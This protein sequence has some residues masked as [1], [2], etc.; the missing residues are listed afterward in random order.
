MGSINLKVLPM[1]SGKKNGG[2]IGYIVQPS[3]VDCTGTM[4]SFFVAPLMMVLGSRIGLVLLYVVLVLLP[5]LVLVLLSILVLVLLPMFVILIMLV[6]IIPVLV[7]V[8]VLLVLVVLVVLVVSLDLV[9]V[10]IS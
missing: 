4:I 1:N 6:P 7:F 9:I 10:F 2:Y 5:I 3:K 8:P